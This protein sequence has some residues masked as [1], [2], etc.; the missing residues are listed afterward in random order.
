MFGGLDKKL[1]FFAKSEENPGFCRCSF[2]CK[3]LLKLISQRGLRR[4]I[5]SKLK[6]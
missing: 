2:L 5:E 6:E 1:V 3:Y 4:E